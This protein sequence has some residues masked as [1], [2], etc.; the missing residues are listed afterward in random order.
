[1]CPTQSAPCFSLVLKKHTAFDFESFDDQPFSLKIL[2]GVQPATLP[3]QP[4]PAIE[5]ILKAYQ[6]ETNA[7]I[8]NT[9]TKNELVL[10]GKFPLI[11]LNVY[12]ARWNGRYATSSYFIAY[13]DDG[14]R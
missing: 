3:V 7:I 10:E 1:M 4:T 2:E 9:L 14:G 8:E 6:A 5:A 12:N 13:Q 11:G